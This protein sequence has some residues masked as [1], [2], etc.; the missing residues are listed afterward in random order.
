MWGNQQTMHR[1]TPF[2]DTR[3]ARDMRRVTVLEGYDT[4]FG[5]RRD[6]P[7]TE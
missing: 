5:F 3:Y 2:D 7:A 6:G 4:G 1:G